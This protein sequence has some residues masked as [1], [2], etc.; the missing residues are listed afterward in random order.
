M[1][2]LQSI[3]VLKQEQ[4]GWGIERKAWKKD[5]DPL[6]TLRWTIYNYVT[7]WV[8]FRTCHRSS[9]GRLIQGHFSGVYVWWQEDLNLGHPP[10]RSRPCP[11]CHAITTEYFST[12]KEFQHPRIDYMLTVM[13]DTDRKTGCQ[14][15]QKVYS[16]ELLLT[17]INSVTVNIL[18]GSF[19]VSTYFRKMWAQAQNICLMFCIF[20][21]VIC[22]LLK[23]LQML[24][25]SMV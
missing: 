15:T 23:R 19:Q 5:K 8:F 13:T 21:G 7:L 12:S 14:P 11:R 25:N 6:K 18:R 10:K 2:E 17:V 16:M 20:V 24:G 4:T 9:V 1:E 22:S 3:Y